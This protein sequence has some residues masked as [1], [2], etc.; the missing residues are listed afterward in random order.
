MKYF[1]L[2][3]SRHHAL[4]CRH[5]PRAQLLFGLLAKNVLVQPEKKNWCNTLKPDLTATRPHDVSVSCFDPK[6][7]LFCRSN[8]ILTTVTNLENGWL[9]MF[10]TWP[11]PPGTGVVIRVPCKVVQARI[12]TVHAMM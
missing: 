9:A 7:G 11:W 5:D 2:V 8:A 4:C 1:E 6:D 3:F 12:W 10:G